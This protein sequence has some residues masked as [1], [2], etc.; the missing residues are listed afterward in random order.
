MVVCEH[1]GDARERAESREPG[2][3]VAEVPRIE[4]SARRHPST[5]P[6]CEGKRDLE[7][8]RMERK[9]SSERLSVLATDWLTGE[10]SPITAYLPY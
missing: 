5:S 6:R 3:R 2:D 8:H 4:K 7:A 10:M 9:M 1:A